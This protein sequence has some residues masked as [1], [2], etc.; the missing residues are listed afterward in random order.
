[1][2]PQRVLE[3]LL[4]LGS[5]PYQPPGRRIPDGAAEHRVQAP[6]DLVD[7]VVV[8]RLDGAVI[9]AGERH[10]APAVE[11]H[12]AGE[13][14][15]LDPGQ[16]VV[17]EQMPG[18]VA[19]GHLHG[20]CGQQAQPPRLEEADH[21]VGVLRAEVLVDFKL[22]QLLLR[23]PL[24]LRPVLELGY[25]E[26]Q[27]PERED[28]QQR[29]QQQEEGNRHGYL[30]D[31]LPY[32]E[33][34]RRRRGRFPRPAQVGAPGHVCLQIAAHLGRGAAGPVALVQVVLQR[35]PEP[36]LLADLVQSAPDRVHVEG[37]GGQLMPAQPGDPGSAA[38]PRPRVAG[39]VPERLVDAV[40]RHV[41][42]LGQVAP[43]RGVHVAHEDQAGRDRLAI[44]IRRLLEEVEPGEVNPAQMGEV[45]GRLGQAQPGHIGEPLP[46]RGH[47]VG[48][49][50]RPDRDADLVW[51][52]ERPPHPAPTHWS[53]MPV[54]S[55]TERAIAAP[56]ADDLFCPQSS[57]VV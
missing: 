51:H 43:Q 45:E 17:G 32:P 2:I 3:W 29:R 13:M 24:D 49:D 40:A 27:D 6:P 21:R 38:G 46:Q 15:R 11:R 20:A 37:A 30:V 39:T 10:P 8:V 50:L 12:P 25:P 34:Q 42:E 1:M 36:G 33:Q 55:R 28:D 4:Q 56:R 22:V 54:F 57:P 23:R 31:G 26:R 44:E 52:R 47:L 48:T 16:A 53:A 9:V 7:E 35:V 41:D 5:A 14:D 19:G 18:P